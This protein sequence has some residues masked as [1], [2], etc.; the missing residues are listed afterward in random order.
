[1]CLLP[2]TRRAPRIMHQSG[3]ATKRA[4]TNKAPCRLHV[5]ATN[6]IVADPNLRTLE[7][8]LKKNEAAPIPKLHASVCIQGSSLSRANSWGETVGRAVP[9]LAMRDEMYATVFIRIPAALRSEQCAM[10]LAAVPRKSKT[11]RPLEAEV[12]VGSAATEVAEFGH[13]WQDVAVDL[14]TP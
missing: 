3:S 10:Y 11:S 7:W 2:R 1:M 9:N 8:F 4:P 12:Q 6:T 14:H 5:K 13:I